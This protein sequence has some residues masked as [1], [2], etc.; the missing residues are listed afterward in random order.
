MLSP[1][2]E[3]LLSLLPAIVT[4]SP[5]HVSALPKAKGQRMWNQ[6]TV[7]R[8]FSTHASKLTFLT[9]TYFSSALVTAAKGLF[10][11]LY[12]SFPILKRHL[13]HY[14]T[15]TMAKDNLNKTKRYHCRSGLVHILHQD[16]DPQ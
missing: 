9:L 16:I 15:E 10:G 3:S 7:N 14:K 2:S 5:C 6:P 11:D 1:L 13:V 12:V 4:K 8:C